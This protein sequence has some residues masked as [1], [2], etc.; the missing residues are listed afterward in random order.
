MFV[1]VLIAIGVLIVMAD[2]EK[3]QIEPFLHYLHL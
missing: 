1:C 3:H 2:A